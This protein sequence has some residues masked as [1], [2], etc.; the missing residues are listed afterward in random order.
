MSETIAPPAPTAPEEE[1]DSDLEKKLAVQVVD[2]SHGV[3]SNAVDSAEEYIRERT[4]QRGIRGIL[5]KIW[6]GNIARDYYRQ[7]EIG[8]GRAEIVE[9]GNLYA[10]SSG[11]Q[12]EHDEAVSAIVDRF[13]SDYD[14]LHEGET[15]QSFE[16]TERGAGLAA[17][18]KQLI[19]SFARGEL[20][21][22]SLIEERTR[23]LAEFGQQAHPNDRERGLLYADNILEVAANARVA[24]EHGLGLERIDA[25]IS[26]KL[27]EAQVG[28]RTEAHL[29]RTDRVMERL[30]SSRAGS[31]VNETTLGTATVIALGAAKVTTKSAVSA[32]GAAVSLGVGA[33]LIGA[34]RE[35]LH[36]G[37]ERQ[38]HLRQRA[39][40]GEL[41][42]DSPRR[43]QLEETR[44]E[45]VSAQSLTDNLTAAMEGL[46]PEDPASLQYLGVA[47]TEARVRI[48]LS[49]QRSLD[50][51][52][53][54][55]KT[56]VESERLALDEQLARAELAVE[57][58]DGY[59]PQE[60]QDIERASSELSSALIGD[61]DQKDRVFRRL[62]R[63]R[64][65][66]MGALAGV[67]G[68]TA[69]LLIQ[70]AHALASGGLAGAG[71]GVGQTVDRMS[72][73]KG[74]FGDS[75]EVDV[76][77]PEAEAHREFFDGGLHRKAVAVK[78][79]EGF[80][81]VNNRPGEQFGWDITGPDGKSVLEKVD[82]DKWQE[83]VAND[84]KTYHEHHI[85][86][87]QLGLGWDSQGNLDWES[88]NALRLAGFDLTQ[89]KLRFYEN[90]TQSVEVSRT[91]QEF[92][93]AHPEQFTRVHRQL[94][95]NNDTPGIYDQNELKLWWG[96]Q[97]ATGMDKDGNYVF[98]VAHMAPEGS[99]HGGSSTDA[100]HLIAEGKMSLALSMT[101]GTQ[102]EVFMVPVD[103]N[104]N[105]VINADSYVGRSLFENRGGHARFVGAYAEAVQE[106]SKNPDGSQ[107]IRMLATV[108]GDNDPKSAADVIEKTVQE[109]HQHF[110]TEL[111]LREANPPTEIPP[112]LPIYSRRGLENLRES[113]GGG[114][115]Y[116]GSEYYVGG[117]GAEQ[118][119][120]VPFARELETNP[121]ADIDANESARR[122]LRSIGLRRFFKATMMD[123]SLHVGERNKRNMA[124]NPKVVVMIP[125]AAHQEGKNIYRTLEQ[126]ANQKDVDFD[127]FEV[128][129][130]ANA[131][132]RG[133]DGKKVKL[134]STIDEIERFQKEHPEVKVRFVKRRLDPRETRIG[135]I[136]KALT[137][138]VISDLLSRK[139]D[140]NEILL[141]SNDA[142]SQW[143]NPK[144]IKTIIDKAAAEPKTDGFLG[145]I[146]WGYDAYKAHPETLAA[147]RLM[148]M[149][150][151]YLRIKTKGVGSSG[152]NFAFR[153]GIY[154]AV[155]G[156]QTLDK[157]EDVMLGRMIRGAR[158]GASTRRPIGFL[159][160][161]SEVTSSA[162]RALANLL[163]S[164]GAPIT[165]W[166]GIFSP[167]D[168]LRTTDFDLRDFDF[169]NVGAVADLIERTERMLNETLDV[170]KS[171]LSDSE[172]PL[173]R[174]GRITQYDPEAL[175][176]IERF[177]TV[178]GLTPRWQSDGSFRIVDATRMLAN[179]RRWQ[180]RH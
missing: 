131:P 24:F 51:I 9:T 81:L 167:Y 74:L 177:L 78:L 48:G 7:R 87:G 57:G 98:N 20:D 148:Q 136:R 65:L 109:R 130:F 104:G 39:E 82:W 107:D 159:G 120:A 32:A 8:R 16:D 79:P 34:V 33:G 164:G 77:G 99:Y 127:D 125:A 52:H 113:S 141:I 60:F 66:K 75:Q 110:M 86:E 93:N 94:W 38:V 147:T 3:A 12:A 112:V 22:D 166:H 30:Y 23:I 35:H 153:P 45:S 117:G 163:E 172:V 161:S 68:V 173:Y 128:V 140:L 29:T 40:G 152:A 114:G 70:E 133:R 138:A 28:V 15:N 121:D 170:Y 63:I 11:S 143:I 100:Q 105:A 92:I 155:G 4:H 13:A 14:L 59:D 179:L 55:G 154:T 157:G 175:R 178:I 116:G 61:I 19:G 56:L 91:P 144:Y 21:Y 101:K 165:Q 89:D 156:Y 84:K 162:R 142:D 46:N 106:M 5:R 176:N 122:Y 90:V 6:H 149:M 126:Y 119:R 111:A 1:L 135:W 31:L 69:G 27:G 47:I 80:H 36:I 95:Y 53:F 62:R 58:I 124:A 134:D 180:A 139:V 158:S 73:I 118:R 146:D 97:N 145:F 50:L 43:Q 44:Y 83:I 76:Q 160:R 151:A 54:S 41:E 10:L 49:D 64:S 150:E 18:V 103:A 96:G 2:V 42:D 123:V 25:A 102:G 115:Y 85:Q 168:A 137:D 132:K 129:V 26:G 37:Q 174:M 71:E 17:N 72:L 88:R 171:D 67:T 169:D 108:V